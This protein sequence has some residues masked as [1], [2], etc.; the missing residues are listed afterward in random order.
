MAFSIVA[1]ADFEKEL[2]RLAKKYPSIKN[3]VAG[4][5][6]KLTIDP[7]HGVPIGNECYK[8]RLA[9]T[10]KGKGKSGGARVI[11]HIQVTRQYLYMLSIY[12]KS[13]AENITD[14]EVVRRLRDLE[15]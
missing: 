14:V 7:H 4:L 9:I 12:D 1:T 13:E 2:K 3:D 10:S 8:I 11:T 15:Y 6:E 5:V